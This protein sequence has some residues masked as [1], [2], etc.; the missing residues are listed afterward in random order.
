M[1][2]YMTNGINDSATIAVEAAADMKEVGGK[3]AKY[4]KNGLLA[5]CS[6][7]GEK[8]LGVITIDN[9]VE[10]KKGDAVTVQIN[11]MGVALLGGTVK[12]GDELAA[13]TTGAFVKAET[14]NYVRAIAKKAGSEGSVIPVVLCNYKI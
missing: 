3:A 13:D 6:T 1:K 11:R 9:D 14:G 4:D 5:L 10:I 7:T 8:C 2:Q 12:A